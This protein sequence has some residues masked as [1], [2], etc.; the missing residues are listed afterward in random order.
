MKSS[1]VSVWRSCTLVIFLLTLLLV[2]EV[3]C[4][5]NRDEKN[6]KFDDRKKR[7]QDQLMSWRNAFEEIQNLAS[8][9][10]EG[11]YQNNNL[12]QRWKAALEARQ[13][14]REMKKPE[15]IA[16]YE[17]QDEKEPLS[18]I[19]VP[20]DFKPTPAREGEPL[21]PHTDIGDK[22]KRIWIVTT[23]ALP[24]MTGTAV[25][26]LLRAAYLLKGRIEA[27]GSVTL[28]VPWLVDAMERNDV[29]GQD[30]APENAESQE[31]YIREWLRNTANMEE[32]SDH[33][34]ILFY[35]AWL[36]RQENSIYSQGDITALMPE[37]EIDI[38]VM[39]EPEHLNWYRDAGESW[40]KKF[41]HV[42]GIVHTNYYVYAQEQPAA[43]IRAPAMKL[44]CSW[45]CRAHCHRIIKLSGALGTFAPEKELVENVHGVR[46]SFLDAGAIVRERLISHPEEDPIFGA[47][48]DPKIYFIGK[49]LWSKGIGTLMGLLKYAEESAGLEV[50]MDMYGGGPDKD[51]AEIKAQTMDL[52]LSF[53]GPIDHAALGDTHK[54]FINPSLSEVLCTTVSEALAMGK[55]VVLPSHPSNDFF[56]QFP[57]CLPYSTKEEFVGNLYYAMTHAPEP[58]TEEYSYAFTWEAATNRFE[59]A[60]SISVAEKKAL[61][62]AINASIENNEIALP[63]LVEDDENR[64]KLTAG[65]R[66]TRSRFRQFR[67]NLSHEIQASKVLPSSI[68]KTIVAEL[69][70]RRDLD[71]DKF[72]SSPKVRLRL[73]PAE[74]DKQL[75]DLY[76][77]VAVDALRVLFGGDYNDNKNV[78]KNNV[79]ETGGGIPKTPKNGSSLN[80]DIPVEWVKSALKKNFPE[81]Y[82]S[83]GNSR[84]SFLPTSGNLNDKGRSRRDGSNTKDGPRMSICGLRSSSFYKHG[85]E[86]R[87]K[88]TNR[89]W[90][91]P[92]RLETLPPS[93]LRLRSRL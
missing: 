34:R 24:W 14:V 23:A 79:R 48:A 15:S 38:C 53:K 44:L 22:S 57:N 59:S 81:T 6:T 67:S 28:M 66:L 89:I 73:S 71:M 83:L 69:D 50:S 84:N 70:K 88:V 56:A 8:A 10:K 36:N 92:P 78:M 7:R 80:E 3:Q 91:T 40:T 2:K 74:L 26:P 85:A 35:P 16:G 31:V 27:G 32:A 58:L 30:K 4:L 41:K 62:K 64:R 54:I 19:S 11:V 72:V 60:G 93:N 25:N 49:M 21:V 13:Q 17:R 87:G 5:D 55:F 52:N 45:M 86:C 75:L 90:R 82:K 39:E 46:R 68:Q 43:V 1:S 47:K 61:F 33:L 37:D 29:Y 42:V 20:I 9:N 51:A 76:N 77:S 63:P 12:F 18:A 65:L